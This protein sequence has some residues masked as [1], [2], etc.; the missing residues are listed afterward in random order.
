MRNKAPLH[1]ITQGKF[2]END[3]TP[4]KYQ[5]KLFRSSYKNSHT[6]LCY[7]FS[8]LGSLKKKKR[9]NQFQLKRKTFSQ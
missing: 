4:E 6:I 2:A 1:T 8:C 7:S 5:I 9:F 3:L